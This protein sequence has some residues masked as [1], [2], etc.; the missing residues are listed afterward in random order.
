[1]NTP[2][3]VQFKV[4]QCVS[5]VLEDVNHRTDAEIIAWL[6]SAVLNARLT[7]REAR[8]ATECEKR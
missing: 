1:M 4:G 5:S 6:R 3:R 8:K 2:M 7:A